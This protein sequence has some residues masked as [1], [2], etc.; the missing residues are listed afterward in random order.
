[1]RTHTAA[2]RLLTLLLY[3]VE[4]P[5]ISLYKAEGRERRILAG[6]GPLARELR[7]SNGGLF[8]QLEW[9]ETRGYLIINR[10]PRIGL[11]DVTVLLPDGASW[12]PAD[13]MD[14]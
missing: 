5:A 2:F 4:H 6:I 1:M 12:T 7:M 10:R 9:L 13:L 8:D 11:V 3:S 14:E